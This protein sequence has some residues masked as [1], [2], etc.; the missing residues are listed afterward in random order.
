MKQKYYLKTN[1]IEYFEKYIH[2]PINIH[3]EFVR[4]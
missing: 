4:K 2:I 1:F 3:K